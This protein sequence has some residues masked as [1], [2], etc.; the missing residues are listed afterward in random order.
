MLTEPDVLC[1]MLYAAV[2]N[3]ALSCVRCV[4]YCHD[5]CKSFL[6]RHTAMYKPS[7]CW[8]SST[9][10]LRTVAFSSHFLSSKLHV[11]YH[12]AGYRKRFLQSIYSIIESWL[13]SNSAVY[14]IQCR[15]LGCTKQRFIL[16]CSATWES[17]RSSWAEYMTEK[18]YYH[19]EYHVKLVVCE[20][21]W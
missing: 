3:S 6:C 7:S 1:A 17:S 15:C 16:Y 9:M 10:I 11:Q 21:W 8:F 13:T 19:A 18:Y 4:A 12:I 5:L 14:L 20:L 2:I